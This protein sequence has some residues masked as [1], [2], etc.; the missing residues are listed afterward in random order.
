MKKFLCVLLILTSVACT[1]SCNKSVIYRDDLSLSDLT[2]T[3][4]GGLNHPIQYSRAEKNYLSDYFSTPEFVSEQDIYFASDGNNINEFGLFRVT[5]GNAEEMEN[6][7]VS[8]LSESFE[9]NRE[10]YDSY[11]P[12]ETAKLRDAEVRRFGNYVAYAILD[13]D[14]KSRFFSAIEDKLTKK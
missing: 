12:E 14:S 11:I 2:E 7:L 9:K 10:F 1:F 4:R 3:V 8:Y 13:R 6:H 5:E